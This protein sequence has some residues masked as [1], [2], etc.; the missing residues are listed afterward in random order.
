MGI[1]YLIL[2]FDV[3]KLFSILIFMLFYTCISSKTYGTSDIILIQLN[4][5]INNNVPI[6]IFSIK[7]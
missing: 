6:H 1:K 4:M 3:Y 7:V 2:V 5:L